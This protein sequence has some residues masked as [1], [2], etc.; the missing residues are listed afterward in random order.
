MHEERGKRES[1]KYDLNIRQVCTS[2]C[3]QHGQLAVLCRGESNHVLGMRIEV[4]LAFLQTILIPMASLHH[5]TPDRHPSHP[6]KPCVVLHYALQDN[7]T[8]QMQTLTQQATTLHTSHRLQSTA[9][10]KLQHLLPKQRGPEHTTWSLNC[11]I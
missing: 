7:M 6:Y 8:Q 11:L 3:L 1:A 10:C 9:F 5:T 4:H 2:N